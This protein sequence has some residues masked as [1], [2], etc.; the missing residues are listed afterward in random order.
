MLWL[1]SVHPSA[2]TGGGSVHTQ[3]DTHTHTDLA[4]HLLVD[5]EG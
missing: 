3:M 5:S 4:K 2:A 1:K